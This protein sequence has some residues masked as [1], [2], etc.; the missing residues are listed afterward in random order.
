MST[1]KLDD[2]LQKALDDYANEI[3]LFF[4][5]ESEEPATKGDINEVARQTMYVLSRFKNE[6]VEYLKHN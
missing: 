2:K 5:E 1:K 6:I 3:H 4:K